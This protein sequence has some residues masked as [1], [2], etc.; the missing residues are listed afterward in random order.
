ML[1]VLLGGYMIVGKDEGLSDT[2]AIVLTCNSRI[3]AGHREGV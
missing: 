1:I 2:S 3:F